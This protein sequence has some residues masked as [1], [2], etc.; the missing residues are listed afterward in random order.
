MQNVLFS[1]R[2]H[3]PMCPVSVRLALLKKSGEEDWRNRINKKQVV[4]K[5]A[6]TER[7]STVQGQGWEAEQT[8]KKKVRLHTAGPPNWIWKEK[9]HCGLKDIQTNKHTLW[10]CTITTT[11]KQAASPHLTKCLLRSYDNEWNV[12]QQPRICHTEP[13]LLN[14][15]PIQY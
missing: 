11:V 4:V 13:S 1:L 3:V 10:R 6:V 9:L 8:Y 12:F 7:H 14:P 2:F 5:V 15:L